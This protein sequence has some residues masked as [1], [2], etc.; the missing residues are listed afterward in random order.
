MKVEREVMDGEQGT[1][2][3]DATALIEDELVAL[4][5][6]ERLSDPWP[7]WD[8][9][10]TEAPVHILPG[11]SQV[12]ITRYAD[13]KAM[14]YDKTTYSNKFDSTG[15]RVDEILTSLDQETADMMRTVAEFTTLQMGKTDDPQHA[16]VRNVAHRFFTPRYLRALE[17]TVQ[18]FI[19]ELLATEVGE[20][21]VFDNTLVTRELALRVM[22]HVIG[23]P[24]VERHV[25]CDLADRVAVAM[26]SSDP[27]VVRDNYYARQEF[28]AY[29]EDTII[30]AYRSGSAP[31]E[32]VAAVM[33]AGQDETLSTVETVALIANFLFG[34]YETT[35]A[36]LTGGT[37]EMLEQRT[38]WEKL[39]ADHELVPTAVEELLRWVS[40]AQFIPRIA[41]RDHTLAGIHV[42]VGQTLI[43]GLA[44]GNRDPD[45][46][47]DA[48][49]LDISRKPRQHLGLGA[50]PHYCLGSALIRLEARLYFTTLAQRYPNL[51]LATP[52]SEL[53][54]QGT[55]MMRAPASMPLR[56]AA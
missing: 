15:S 53:S 6:N 9:A 24:Q 36:L 27:A 43:A 21:G 35:Y 33:D 7:V 14:L 37:I 2:S 34:G 18:A 4:F 12:V 56:V 30:G 54:W 32:L 52:A 20:N 17:P 31:N 25:I 46:I 22:T 39:T 1:M 40:P 3:A 16:R 26:D 41:T 29:I 44:A 49:S 55:A 11:R 5:A 42:P 47:A 19:D 50:G 23:A 13:V 8:R 48:G 51:E 28:N 45:F 10:R 38:E